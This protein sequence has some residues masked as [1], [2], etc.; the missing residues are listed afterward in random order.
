MYDI[1][2][3][4]CPKFIV[5]V[6]KYSIHDMDGVGTISLLGYVYFHERVH[7][8]SRAPSGDAK[9]GRCGTLV[10]KTNGDSFWGII[11]IY[12]LSTV[13]IQSLIYNMFINDMIG[14][15]VYPRH[16]M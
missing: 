5:H 4:I 6:G 10:T 14:F 9:R 8:I 2:T 12:Y 11:I 13:M 16:S 7:D 1:F 3:Y 15:L